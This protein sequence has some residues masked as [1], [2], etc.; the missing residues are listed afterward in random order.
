[1]DKAVIAGN[2]TAYNGTGRNRIARMLLKEPE[3]THV[4]DKHALSHAIHIYPNPTA[5]EVNLQLPPGAYD[6][7]ITNDLGAVVLTKQIDCFGIFHMELPGPK[8]FYFV[9]FKNSMGQSGAV[10]V[11]KK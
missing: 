4:D 2:F 7:K 8:G 3:D 6:M 5:G 9:S 1:D 11:L 10:K